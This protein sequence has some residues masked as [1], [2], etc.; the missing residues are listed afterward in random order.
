MRQ[1]R[2]HG[3]HDLR[4]DEVELPPATERDVVVKV[5]AFGICGSDLHFV[6]Q[7]GPG[8]P[9]KSPIPVGHEVAGVIAA[10]GSEVAGLQVGQRVVVDPMKGG[11]NIGIGSDAGGCGEFL[12]V[13]NATLGGAIHPIPDAMSFQRAVLAEPLAVGRHAIHV[14]GAQP[15]DKVVV[16]GAGPIGLGM[17]ASLHYLGVKDIVAV[18]VVEERLQRALALGAS[19]VV[20]PARSD[21]KE[22]LGALFGVVRHPMTGQKSVGADLFLDAAG[23]GPLIA[24]AVGMARS[25]ARIV[26][27]AAHKQPLPLDMNQI[28]TKELVVRGS[29]CYPTEFPDVLAMLG[30]DQVDLTALVS[31]V[32]PV[33]EF[34]AAFKTAADGK[35]SAK[36]IVA[37]AA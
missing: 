33:E 2:L 34:E 31:H 4:L 17:V 18:D 37:F 8:G 12:L 36:V 29:I 3:P 22:E 28:M 16:L 5:A 27:V 23:F 13:R 32:F 7:G 30:D 15:G 14:G 20:N 10:L 11:N 9:A 21:L 24:D 6:H 1:V 35:A 25:G 26:I 19:A